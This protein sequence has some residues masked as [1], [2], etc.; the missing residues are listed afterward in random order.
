MKRSNAGGAM[1]WIIGGLSA[2]AIIAG[3]GLLLNDIT[4]RQPPPRYLLVNPGV[5]E[6][7]PVPPPFTPA[8]GS[9]LP[10]A[11]PTP[12]LPQF[13]QMWRMTPTTRP[14][15]KLPEGKAFLA[16]FRTI[17]QISAVRY[18]H[19]PYPPLSRAELGQIMIETEP[20]QG[21]VFPPQTF[22]PDVRLWQVVRLG[23]DFYLRA[24]KLPEGV[25]PT[26]AYPTEVLKKSTVVGGTTI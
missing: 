20:P 15:T 18:G 19:H 8:L 7:R 11:G 2:A 6:T 22:W 16:S 3:V 23:D 5:S 21:R 17:L 13:D 1:R 25:R 12:F 14:L 24:W 9:S 26:T 10:T 4:R